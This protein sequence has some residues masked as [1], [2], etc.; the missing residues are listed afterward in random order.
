MICVGNLCL[1]WTEA[2]SGKR[3]E[4]LVLGS[5]NLSEVG[6]AWNEVVEGHLLHSLIREI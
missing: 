1:M 5:Y 4:G 3:K 6:G 2:G